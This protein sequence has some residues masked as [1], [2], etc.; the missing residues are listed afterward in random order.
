MAT[1]VVPPPIST[2][3]EPDGSVTG[4]LAP[5]AAAIGSSIKKTRR[6]PAASADSW[7]ARR[8]TAVEPDGTHIT[9]CGLAN[10]TRPF[11]FRIKCLIISS[12][13]SKSAITP[14]A[15]GLIAR[16]LPGVL[17]SITFASSP[18]AR[19]CAFPLTSAIATTDGS[20]KTMPRPLTYT[21]VFAV[22]KSMP[23]SAEKRPRTAP[24]IFYLQCFSR[25]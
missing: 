12:A 13:T 20:S 21:S 18:T 8:S 3:I 14:S 17:P 6:A 5:I 23:I 2:T 1:S 15:I 10:D 11:T 9:T 25:H 16:M 4:K 7:I 24:N 19:T 22:P